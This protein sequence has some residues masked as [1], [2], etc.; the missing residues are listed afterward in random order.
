M[1]MHHRLMR[2]TIDIAVRKA[3]VDIQKDAKRSIR[4]LVDLGLFFSRS[5]NQK[6][7][8][9]TAKKIVS[10]PCNPYNRLISRLLAEVEHETVKTVGINLGYS[11]LTYGSGKLKKMHMETGVPL[12]WIILF[13]ALEACGDFLRFMEAFIGQ[14]SEMGIY[15]Y[16]LRSFGKEDITALCN[17]AKHF[18]ECTFILDTEPEEITEQNAGAINAVHNMLVYV[19]S[20]R[21][22]LEEERC[23]NA[24]EI[25]RKSR[26]FYGFLTGCNDGNISRVTAPEYI[27]SAILH[28]NR[29]GVYVADEDAS[30]ACKEE[31]Y[32]FV[33]SERSEEGQ[34]LVTFDWFSDIRHISS[35]ILSGGGCL[36]IH[37]AEKVYCDYMKL[38]E[39]L[40]FSLIDIIE[41][42]MPCLDL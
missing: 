42:H 2:Q 28:G 12:P 20:Q 30:E 24:F 3:M 25:L 17:I 1:D 10:N 7:F 13:D 21:G 29:F 18:G 9:S 16:I 32:S 23:V 36:A 34:P 37:A 4:N 40:E 35:R 31:L 41:R 26:C 19:R 38:R 39:P 14:G 27:Q 11:S 15:C 8:F 22:E 33:C 5:E 6:W